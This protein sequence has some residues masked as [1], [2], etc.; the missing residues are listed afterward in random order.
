[1]NESCYL[2]QNDLFIMVGN[3]NEYQAHLATI[4]MYPQ[5]IYVFYHF[6]YQN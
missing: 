1:M 6:A 2:L 5:I 4:N 3:W